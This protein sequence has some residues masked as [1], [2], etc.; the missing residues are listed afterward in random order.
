MK[1]IIPIIIMMLLAGC[2]TVS[3]YPE[4][5]ARDLNRNEF[6]TWGALPDIP[7]D[8]CVKRMFLWKHIVGFEIRS[9]RFCGDK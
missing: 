2:V 5:S 3:T 8:P 7:L 1:M 9:V 6:V 4:I